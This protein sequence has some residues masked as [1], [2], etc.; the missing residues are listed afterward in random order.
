MTLAGQGIM[1]A[2]TF[3]AAEDLGAGRLVR[4][5]PQHRAVGF[6]IDPSHPSRHHLSTKVRSFI[7]LLAER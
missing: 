2:P 5:L 7:E 1:L 3:L 4:L 6:A